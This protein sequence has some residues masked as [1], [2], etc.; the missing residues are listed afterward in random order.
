MRLLFLNYMNASLA[1]MIRSL[2]LATATSR[3]GH[4][5]TLCFMHPTFR[6][7]DS[8]REVLAT[9]SGDRLVIRYPPPA[10]PRA[11]APASPGRVTEA[12]PSAAGL[13]LQAAASLRY[14][15]AET[16][17]VRNARPDVI[18]ARP[19]HVFSFL[20][21]SRLTRTPLV[22]DT[23]GPVLGLRFGMTGRLVVDGLA[24]I[25]ELLYSSRRD[26]PAS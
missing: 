23:D 22:L 17:L 9:R 5:V 13:A 7:P 24:P 11:G 18:V 21:T 14:V 12:R 20:A 1:T 25:D 26:D 8:F 6:P 3:L 4:D 2:E 16:T 15:P 19:D 10:P